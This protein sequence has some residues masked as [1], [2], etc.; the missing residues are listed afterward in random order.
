MRHICVPE[1]LQVC[2]RHK[3][4][5]H[6][7]D[8][9]VTED[10]SYLCINPAKLGNTVLAYKPRD[11]DDV[12]RES[13]FKDMIAGVC[14]SYVFPI[15]DYDKNLHGDLKLVTLSE[16]PNLE[17]PEVLHI[18]SMHRFTSEDI[19]KYDTRAIPP[20]KGVKKLYITEVSRSLDFTASAS[21]TGTGVKHVVIDQ[22]SVSSN[23]KYLDD[24]ETVFRS[25]SESLGHDNPP[26]TITCDTIEV[27]YS[28]PRFTGKSTDEG[29][30]RAE[31]KNLHYNCQTLIIDQGVDGFV[32]TCSTLILRPTCNFQGSDGFN[33]V[34]PN[35]TSLRVESGEGVDKKK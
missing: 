30:S 8:A 23:P 16:N 2:D 32:S 14:R 27:R 13:G 26:C 6:I 29:G 34:A 1:L 10:N 35:L 19:G 18:R 28:N 33:F 11:K 4:A 24:Y 3:Y 21:G 7:N 15:F 31:G 25:M 22:I 9:E 5:N 20:L 17:Y 12:E